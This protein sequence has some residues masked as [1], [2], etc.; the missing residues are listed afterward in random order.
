[1]EKKKKTTCQIRNDVT[2]EILK[3]KKS[4]SN[5]NQRTAIM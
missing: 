4:L 5:S 3:K 1:M 2:V